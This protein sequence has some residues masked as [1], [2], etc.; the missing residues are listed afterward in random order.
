MHPGLSVVA[1]ISVLLSS[2][3]YWLPAASGT[4]LNGCGPKAI[5]GARLAAGAAA[6]A[7]AAAG[8]ASWGLPVGPD[9]TT[10]GTVD[11]G[12]GAEAAV[13]ISPERRLVLAAAAVALMAPREMGARALRGSPGCTAQSWLYTAALIWIA[14]GREVDSRRLALRSCR[15]VGGGRA[16]QGVGWGW[17]VE[18]VK[19]LW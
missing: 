5:R 9:R 16:Q 15:E 2:T 1:C 14:P 8:V 19:G 4:T 10:A 11:T 12:V 13:R 7:A 18:R 6:E 17:R 3:P